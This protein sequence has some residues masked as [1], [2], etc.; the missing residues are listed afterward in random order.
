MAGD[1]PNTMPAVA[2]RSQAEMPRDSLIS[3]DISDHQLGRGFPAFIDEPREVAIEG[4]RTA[5]ADPGR[6][7]FDHSAS[8]DPSGNARSLRRF[9]LEFHGCARQEQVR[10]LDLSID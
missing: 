7:Q 3:I 5:I 6:A 2:G 1:E 8:H 10:A 9:N 4:D